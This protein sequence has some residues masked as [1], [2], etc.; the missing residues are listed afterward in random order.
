[1]GTRLIKEGAIGKIKEVYSWV[2]VTGNER[3]RMF[4]PPPSLQSARRI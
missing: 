2:G 1:M 3:T 4:Q